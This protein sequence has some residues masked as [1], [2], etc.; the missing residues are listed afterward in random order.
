MLRKFEKIINPF[1]KIVRGYSSGPI[2]SVTSLRNNSEQFF[3][4]NKLTECLL[5]Q[6]EPTSLLRDKNLS[7][8]N[9]S[10]K[11]NFFNPDER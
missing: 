9:F 10:R 4:N 5:N 7:Q 2:S 8:Y 11:I 3:F 6:E 1:L